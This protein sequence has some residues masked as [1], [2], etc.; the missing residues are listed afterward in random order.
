MV[1]AVALAGCQKLDVPSW[2]LLV[3]VANGGAVFWLLSVWA[4][5][6]P[7]YEEIQRLIRRGGSAH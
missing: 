6:H 1:Q 7:V 2:S 4:F 3:L 5:K